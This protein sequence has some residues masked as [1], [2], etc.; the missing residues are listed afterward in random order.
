MALLIPLA[1]CFIV[2]YL[3][4]T[5]IYNL[6]FHPLA[7]IPGPFL[8]R[9]SYLPSF[10]HACKGDRHV[11][12]WKNFEKYGDKF[13]TA[14]NLILFNSTRA[15][16]DIYG[17]RSNCKRSG[18]YR[19]WQRNKDDIHTMNSTDPALHAK[20][21]KLLNLVFTEQ[22]LKA[23]SPLIV[24]HIDRWIDLLTEETEDQGWTCPHNMA[25]RV[26]YLVFDILGDLCFGQSFNTKEP[27]ENKLKK[28]PHF[29]MQQMSK[30]PIFELLLYMQ[31]RGLNKFLEPLKKPEIKGWNAFIDESVD[32]RLD[33]H[34]SGSS[35]RER[36]DM[37]HFILNAIDPDTN[38]PAFSNR[39]TLLSETRL[40]V[41]AGTDTTALTLS[42]LFFYLANNPLVMAKLSAEIRSTFTSAY[43]IVIGARLSGC[44]YL[45]ACVD[46]TLRLS[47]PAPGELPR[48][49]LPGGAVIDGHPYP[50]GTVVGC[51]A[52]SM[53]RDKHVYGDAEIYRPERWIPSSES[54]GCNTAAD[55]LKLKKAFHP[56]SIGAMNC[57]GQNLATLEL[58][59]V[60]ARTVWKTDFRLAPAKGTVD[61]QQGMGWGQRYSQQYVVKDA[62][63]CFKDG[64]SLQFKRR[65]Y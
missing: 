42:A 50:A 53:G 6:L 2:S 55:V 24:S 65:A 44:K 52:W 14:P 56:F 62:Y 22:S 63:L 54:E 51:A 57:A 58:L 9:I 49:V 30:S 7:S 16:N 43:E 40:L 28:I 12:I 3:T 59:L 41:L 37:F 19:V 13:R 23:A 4:V 34:R 10:Y 18:F 61:D 29:V 15:F 31:P 46:E 60:S 21:R 36:Q 25:T 5:T 64:P 27:G 35:G 26:D 45:R 33:T 47:H 8:S 38:L 32:T 39:V 11:W 1:L 48:E 20:K 17:S